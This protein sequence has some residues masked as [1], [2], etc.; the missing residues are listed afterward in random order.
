MADLQTE[1][2]TKVIPSLDS[3]SFDDEFGSK[4]ELIVVT[5]NPNPVTPK[6]SAMRQIFEFFAT[7]GKPHTARDCA[8]S[9]GNDRKLLR[10]SASMIVQ[11]VNRGF[12]QRAGSTEKGINLYEWSGKPWKTM[13]REEVIKKANLARKEK[14]IA[15][16]GK[17]KAKELKVKTKAAVAPVE[18]TPITE[19]INLDKLTIGEARNLYLALKKYFGS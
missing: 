3:L 15:R 16:K 8:E 18:Q 12:L 10:D 11:L 6:T 13:S 1:L 2:M 17:A 4:S 19:H 5:E 9:F 14:F 7:T